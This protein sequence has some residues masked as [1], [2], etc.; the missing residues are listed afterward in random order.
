MSDPKFFPLEPRVLSKIPL[1]LRNTEKN[2]TYRSGGLNIY[3]GEI[4]GT[5]GDREVSKGDFLFSIPKDVAKR[6]LP[7]ASENFNFPGE[8][9]TVH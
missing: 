9:I 1:N 2:E 5:N 3:E 7:T 8:P 4:T 6:L